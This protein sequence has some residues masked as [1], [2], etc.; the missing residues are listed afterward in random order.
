MGNTSCEPGIQECICSFQKKYKTGRIEDIIGAYVLGKQPSCPEILS[1][2][3]HPW[4]FQTKQSLT[5]ITSTKL[6]NKTCYIHEIARPKKAPPYNKN[7]ILEILLV[8]YCNILTGI[9][10]CYF[11]TPQEIGCLQL[12]CPTCCFSE[13]VYRNMSASLSKITLATLAD[14]QSQLSTLQ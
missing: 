12:P 7:L 14:Y 1:L 13:I 5:P 8:F 9:F 10:T 3:F 6:C 11:L 4:K 2:V